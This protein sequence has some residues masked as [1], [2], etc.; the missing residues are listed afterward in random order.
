MAWLTISNLVLW[1]L[2]IATI[3]VVVGL[4]RQVGV[5]HLRV[6]PLGAGRPE[7][8]PQIGARLHLPPVV[9]LRGD[10]TQVLVPGFLS[11]ITFA[12]PG[13]G[14]CG[15]TM[16]AV[17]RLRA[18]E[19]GVRFV[20]AVDGE[21]AQALK[22]AE[23]YGLMDVVGSETLAVPV[24]SRPFV[25]VLSSDGTVLGAGVPNTLEQ[26]EILLATARYQGSA[27]DASAEMGDLPPGHVNAGKPVA[28]LALVD[29]AADTEGSSDH[30]E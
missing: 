16:E 18:V 9:S 10:A 1:V 27:G 4:A 23:S 24:V 20:V 7:D 6:R 14:A 17:K 19:R 15:P 21:Q 28:E 3:V 13:C 26:L 5:L 22:Y 30:G 11:L 25:V 8:G 12:N 29:F 2:Q